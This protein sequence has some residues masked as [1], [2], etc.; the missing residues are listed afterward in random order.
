MQCVG[1]FGAGLGVECAA[2]SFVVC[3]CVCVCVCVLRM[4]QFGAG[5][6]E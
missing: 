6:G 1:M 3:V 5:V 2:G 4:G